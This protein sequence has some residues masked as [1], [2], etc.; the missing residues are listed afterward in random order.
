MPLD[1]MASR[2]SLFA[3]MRRRGA[4]LF[5]ILVLLAGVSLMREAAVGWL[6]PAE[7]AWE[8][9]LAR[10]LTPP[11]PSPELTLVEINDQT[12]AGHVWP[13]AS[14]EFAVFFN[15][16]LP[17]TP[18]G[19]PF[20]PDV[21]GVEPVLN[22]D[23]GALA[24]EERNALNDRALHDGI[25]RAPKV[26]LGGRLGWSSEADSVQPLLPVT[27]LKGVRGDVGKLPAFT[28]VD[29]W[30]EESLRLTT[31]PGWMNVPPP[32]AARG[33]CPLLLRYRGQPV[34]TMPLQLAL[35]WAKVTPDEV[36]V[37]LGKEITFGSVRIPIDEAGCMQ[38]NFGAE[39]LRLGYD[40]LIVAR[41]QIDA[42]QP[43]IF[44]PAAFHQKVVLLARADSAARTLEVPSGKQISA[45]EL[46]AYAVGTI[47]KAA[48]PSRI[49]AWLDWGLIGLAALVSFWLPRWKT[50]RM[51]LL[52]ILC[53]AAY[54]AGALAL[55]RTQLLALP[56][57]LPLGLAL[58][59]LVLRFFAKPILR[60]IMF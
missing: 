12:L 37:E 20:E 30:A 60:V 24:G 35:L 2:R 9:Q 33:K 56:G 41:H 27:V 39:P 5:P 32:F 58:W 15:A 18:G 43:P 51:A 6:L 3:A 52:V 8:D 17:A 57:V 49:T 26:A 34:P 55:F 59:L 4:F 36:E 38:V 1:T 13:W 23:H 28:S 10:Q 22:Y 47:Q 45:G 21:I 50:S 46:A 11:L 29:G 14:V 31:Q 7:A 44:P 19:A 48:H 40:D 53:E 54:V 42:G 25:L 16:V